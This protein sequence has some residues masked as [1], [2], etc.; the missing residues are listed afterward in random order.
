MCSV[1]LDNHRLIYRRRQHKKYGC[2]INIKQNIEK[3]LPS[4]QVFFYTPTY[5][6]MIFQSY[7]KKFQHIIIGSLKTLNDQALAKVYFSITSTSLVAAGILTKTRPLSCEKVISLPSALTAAA[8]IPLI[9]SI[10]FS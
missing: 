10:K 3:H 7:S 9:F 5:S 6:T 2:H 4:G 8:S 1:N